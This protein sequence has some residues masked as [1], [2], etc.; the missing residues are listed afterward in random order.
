MINAKEVREDTNQGGGV[1]DS[2]LFYDK[3]EE[4]TTF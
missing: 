4:V 1:W 2:P 3:K